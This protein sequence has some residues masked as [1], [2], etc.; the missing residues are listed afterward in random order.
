MSAAAGQA[1]PALTAE[2]QAEM[3]AVHDELHALSSVVSVEE[4][5]RC[6]RANEWD[7]QSAQQF[8]ESRCRDPVVLR[9][10][11]LAV[12]TILAEEPERISLLY[13]L[14]F[15]KAN[16]GFESVGDGVGGS[17]SL[18]VKGG[19][20]G[21]AVA[22]A[23]LVNQQHRRAHCSVGAA[24]TLDAAIQ[25]SSAVSS[26]HDWTHRSTSGV[27]V[28]CSNGTVWSAPHVI[29]AMAPLAAAN[30]VFDPP[31][32][33]RKM[34]A[35]RSL[36]MAAAAKVI[37][38][39]RTPFWIHEDPSWA[40]NAKLAHFTTYGPVYNIFHTEVGGLP[41][42]VGLIVGD[43]ARQWT[44]LPADERRRVVLE[45]YRQVYQSDEA[46]APEAYIDN[47]WQSDQWALG[48]YGGV[49][50]IGYL[51]DCGPFLRVATDRVLWAGTETATEWVGYFEGALVSGE[52]A[53]TDVL[54]SPT[55][56]QQLQQQQ[57]AP[58]AK[59]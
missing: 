2:Q 20:G 11:R 23:D 27:R 21:F 54:A 16:S 5:W 53:A 31:L 37:V 15:L 36:P 49:A 19:M 52:R 7:A 1:A 55:M 46:L 18:K 45:Q 56:Q 10:F 30:I 25:L 24:T 51:T 59:L 39:Y 43:S 33:D 58:T 9:E 42:L 29:V 50:P 44:K 22:F 48:C 6:G 38:L 12:Q 47:E 3:Q 57:Q 40:A 17:Q 8:F 13:L 34:C 4:P 35:L 26:I 28:R 32:P 14:F 41:G